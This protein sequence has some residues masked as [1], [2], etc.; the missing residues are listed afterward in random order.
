MDLCRRCSSGR[1][2]LQGQDGQ[3]PFMV[4]DL[5]L[6]MILSDQ[7]MKTIDI[8]SDAG[9]ELPTNNDFGTGQKCHLLLLN[10][11]QCL[12]YLSELGSLVISGVQ[13]AGGQCLALIGVAHQQQLAAR[14]GQLANDGLCCLLLFQQCPTFTLPA[15]G[16]AWNRQTRRIIGRPPRITAMI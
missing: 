2:R 15:L 10:P 6:G 12:G 3:R 1:R 11:R 14:F 8:D 13:Q 4:M 7:Q 9:I 5:A 16:L